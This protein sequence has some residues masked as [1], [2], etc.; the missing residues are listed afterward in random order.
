[1]KMQEDV[2]FEDKKYDQWLDLTLLAIS[3]F[4]DP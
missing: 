2:A 1:M 4:K 3:T